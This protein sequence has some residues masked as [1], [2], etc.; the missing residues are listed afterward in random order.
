[1]NIQDHNGKTYYDSIQVSVNQRMTDGFQF[2]TAYTY[3][4]T[5]DWW[6]GGVAIPEFFYLNKF[7]TI[8]PYKLTF[9]TVYEL[10]FGAGKKFLSNDSLAAKLAGGWQVNSFVNWQNGSLFSVT[11]SGTSLNAPGSTQRPDKVKPGPVQVFTDQRCPTCMY[12]DVTAFK[13]VTEPRFGNG[14]IRQ[15]RGPSSPNLDMSIFRTFRLMQNKTLQL[16]A[17]V[18]NLTNTPHYD[19]PSGNI[20]SVVF[21][22]DGSVAALNGAGGITDV[23]RTGRQ[24]DEREWR[25]G[26]RFG[27]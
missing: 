17:E 11:G 20:N 25:F 22:P 27:F 18:F 21:N 12:F 4:R 15:V 26:V 6:A 2:T 19:N 24:Y 3:S 10:P 5:T 9:S 16:R 8:N 1:M 14:G 7:T 13:S 23:V